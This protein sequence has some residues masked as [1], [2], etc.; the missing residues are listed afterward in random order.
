MMRRWSATRRS[1]SPRTAP[2]ARPVGTVVATDVDGDTLTF[3][4]SDSGGAFAIDSSG[5]ITVAD[6]SKVN[7][8]A[9]PAYNLMVTVSDP[10]GFSDSGK[11]TINVTNVNDPPTV[12][13][14]VADVSVN[15]GAPDMKI[16]I[17]GVF[18]DQDA[19][20]VLTISVVNS[21]GRW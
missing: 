19:G 20:D 12:A 7:F 3:V 18:A 16:D 15:E 10:G 11:I 9:T 21:N 14:P 6:S 2:P 13:A 8:E 5:K 17:S 4:L 1:A